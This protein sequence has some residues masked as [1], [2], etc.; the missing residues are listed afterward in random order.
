MLE[1]SLSESIECIKNEIINE[2]LIKIKRL[3]KMK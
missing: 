2:Q 3:N 1:Q